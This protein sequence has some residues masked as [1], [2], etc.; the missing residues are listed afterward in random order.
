MSLSASVPPPPEAFR[1]VVLLDDEDTSPFSVASGPFGF[2]PRAVARPVDEADL[3]ILL[4]HCR[5][6]DIAVIPRG[7]G[8]AMPGGNVGRALVLDLTAPE[9]RRIG[10]VDERRA[11]V[12]GSAAVASDVEEA[13]RRGGH[14]F[15]PL[16]SS[17]HRCTLGGMAGTN[18]AGARSYRHGAMRRW[19][20]GMVVLTADGERLTLGSGAPLPL[21][22]AKGVQ[23]ALVS[24]GGPGALLQAWPA[25]R[26]NSS[27]YALDAFV[28]T[29]DPVQLL[30]G[31]EGTLGV[32]TELTLR[33]LPTPPRTGLVLL[34]LP[35][36]DLIPAAVGVADAVGTST[37]EFLGRRLLELVAASGSSIPGSTG[38]PRSLMVLEV[39]GEEDEVEASLERIRTEMRSLGLDGVEAR[40]P[41]EME[42][43]WGIRR[44][45]SPTIQA[46]AERGLRSVQVV[47]DSVVPPEMLPRYVEGVETILGSRAIDHVLFGHAGDGNLHLN[48]LVD[49]RDP[50]TRP[51]LGDV[52]DEVAQLVVEL[53][54]TLTGEHGDGRLRAP[55]LPRIWAPGPLAAFGT[56]KQTFDPG[57]ILNPGVI[58]PL[59][60]QDPLDGLG[61]PP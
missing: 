59:E 10:P 33:L 39:E 7:A 38:I 26:K 47:E 41:E 1:G 16:P 25:L 5:D 30:V 49:L 19:V 3:A 48:P 2:R 37:C 43:I 27:G 56:L 44:S 9:F 42:R 29:G 14:T 21:P 24:G 40:D 45:A 23:A 52:L 46:M 15:P 11:M 8:T 57:G 4:A 50:L 51:M 12:V 17:A 53:G 31:S 54:G 55:L 58:L 28:K 20:D 18:A 60:G 35:S 22:L 6:Q 32:I 36:D 34:F 61:G 13:A